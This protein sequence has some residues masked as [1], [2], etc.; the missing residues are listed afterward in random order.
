MK[1]KYTASHVISSAGETVF[2]LTA[3]EGSYRLPA[4][5]FSFNKASITVRCSSDYA[6]GGVFTVNQGNE[7]G[8]GL[9]PIAGVPTFTLAAGADLGEFDINVTGKILTL[10]SAPF[11]IT[12]GTATITV[13]GKR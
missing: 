10:T 11:Q 8:G 3:E 5:M 1:G 12:A 9:F 6:G 13:V 7:I 4:E 2:T